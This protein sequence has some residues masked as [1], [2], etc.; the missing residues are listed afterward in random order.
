MRSLQNRPVKKLILLVLTEVFLCEL[1]TH[2]CLIQQ[3]NT[4]CG[5]S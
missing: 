4:Y 3:W 1:T 2:V 5:Y